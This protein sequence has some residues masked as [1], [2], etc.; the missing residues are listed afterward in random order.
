MA[1]KEKILTNKDLVNGILEKNPG[2]DREQYN[3]VSRMFDQLRK[4]GVTRRGYRLNSRSI[5]LIDSDEGEDPRTIHL[6]H[7]YF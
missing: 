4:V 3:R 5:R 1:E 6:Q 2:I 7:G